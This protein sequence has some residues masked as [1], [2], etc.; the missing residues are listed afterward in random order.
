[1]IP[2]YAIS[3]SIAVYN[4]NYILIQMKFAKVNKIIIKFKDCNIKCR[5]CN[6]P[7]ENQCLTCNFDR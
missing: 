1:M 6:G 2:V 4:F 5:T 3:I 7:S